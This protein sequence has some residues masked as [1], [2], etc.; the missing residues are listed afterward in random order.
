[1]LTAYQYTDVEYASS[2]EEEIGS[3]FT[4]EEEAIYAL[5][6]QLFDSLNSVCTSTILNTMKYLI[7]QK[8]M[9]KQ[10]EEITQMTPD[11]V[12]VTHH[13]QVDKAQENTTQEI[14]NK[15]YDFLEDELK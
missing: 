14:R 12:C 11:D 4:S 13:R 10:M 3:F 5:Y 15:L 2:Q 9:R 1:M 6:E 7:S 8:G